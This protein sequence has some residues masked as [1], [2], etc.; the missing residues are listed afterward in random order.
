[1]MRMSTKGHHATRIMV[2]L[3]RT[4]DRP[5]SKGEIGEA[6]GIAPGYVQQLMI[7]LTD[8]GLVRSHRGRA[9]GFSISRSPESI[10]VQEV[11]L[12]TEGVFELAPCVDPRLSCPR[13]ET[14]P[15]HVLWSK[16]TTMVNDLFEQTTIADLLHSGQ[17]LE[18]RLN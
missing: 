10:S 2:R 9:G 13:T 12:A 16:A 1:M 4:P 14:C 3:A 18:D 7:R 17:R 6:E 15:A 11:I 5:V 8:A